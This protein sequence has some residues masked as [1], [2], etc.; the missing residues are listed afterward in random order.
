MKKLHLWIISK[1]INFGYYDRGWFYDYLAWVLRTH[2]VYIDEF[3]NI[4]VKLSFKF[5]DYPAIDAMILEYNMDKFHKENTEFINNLE[6]LD[7][8]FDTA[9]L[10]ETISKFI[11]EQSEHKKEM[12]S[13]KV[14]DF[15]DRE[16]DTIE[17]AYMEDML[18]KYVI[19]VPDISIEGLKMKSAK[20]VDGDLKAFEAELKSGIDG[21]NDISTIKD[22]NEF[23]YNKYDI[24]T[25][26]SPEGTSLWEDIRKFKETH[27]KNP[28][29]D[30]RIYPLTGS[31]NPHLIQF[32]AVRAENIIDPLARIV[33]LDAKFD[34]TDKSSSDKLMEA[35]DKAFKDK[36]VKSD[37]E[38]ES[39][40]PKVPR[41]NK[42]SSKKDRPSK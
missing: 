10:D 1:L 42:K 37:D 19:E 40:A 38:S 8:G 11:K 3:I 16:L 39:N 14:K 4:K 23:D 2:N 25:G 29:K 36:E 20:I 32:S 41:M 27:G 24:I 33:T 6:H 34:Y 31:D 22:P 12:A 21:V 18:K 26:L 15:V 28:S 17:K 7:L 13:K 5:N 35:L 9:K 30:D